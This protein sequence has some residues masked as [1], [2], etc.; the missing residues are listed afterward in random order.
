MDT[1]RESLVTL[2][3]RLERERAQFDVDQHEYHGC[4]LRRTAVWYRRC[5]GCVVICIQAFLFHA[6]R[7]V[8][9]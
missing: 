2:R 3:P 7:S 5:S 8:V 1:S 9:W 4:C 6:R